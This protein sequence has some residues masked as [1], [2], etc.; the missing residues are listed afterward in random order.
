M[1]DRKQDGGRLVVAVIVMAFPV[2]AVLLFIISLVID[3]VS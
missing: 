2:L 3:T 1:T